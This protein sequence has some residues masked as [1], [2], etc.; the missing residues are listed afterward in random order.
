[1]TPAPVRVYIRYLEDS[2]GKLQKR[3]NQA[4]GRVE[5]LDV[6]K[7]KKSTNSSKPLASDSPGDKPKRKKKMGSKRQPGAP[8]AAA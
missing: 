4:E 2:V 6:R 3:F 5:K 1:M 8:T 7:R